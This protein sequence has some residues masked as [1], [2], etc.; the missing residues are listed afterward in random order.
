MPIAN[1]SA[2][3]SPANEASTS[4]A[5]STTAGSNI[6]AEL[7]SYF[8]ATRSPKNPAS[9]IAAHVGRIRR[10]EILVAMND[11]RRQRGAQP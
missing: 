3:P 5:G 1:S 11:I 6:A 2:A 10:V 8:A 7:S 9:P 4:T